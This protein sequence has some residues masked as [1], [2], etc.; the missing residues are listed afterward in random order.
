[1]LCAASGHHQFLLPPATTY[2]HKRTHTRT[3]TCVPPADGPLCAASGHHH[4]LLPPATTYTHKRTHTHT[5]AARRWTAWCSCW[6]PPPSPSSAYSYCSH[7]SMPPSC[8]PCTHCCSCCPKAM[9]SACSACGCRWGWV[10]V[11]L[12][13]A[14]ICEHARTCEQVPYT[15]CHARTCARY[16]AMNASILLS[17]SCMHCAHCCCSCCPKATLCSL[18]ALFALYLLRL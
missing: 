16:Y 13:C 17:P 4:F 18:P 3:N 8:V 10:K 6:T 2:T 1:M 5:C 12:C 14:I 9:R 7:A 11:G 15:I